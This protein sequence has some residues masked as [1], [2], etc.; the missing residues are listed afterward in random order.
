MRLQLH[1]TGTIMLS[2]NVK[3]TKVNIKVEVVLTFGSTGF[4]WL[5]CK[6]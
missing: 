3:R 4:V 2:L 1:P 5:K 6:F